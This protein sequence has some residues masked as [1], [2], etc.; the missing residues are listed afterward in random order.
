MSESNDKLR[1]IICKCCGGRCNTDQIWDC[2]KLE[3]TQEEILHIFISKSDVEKAI[4]EVRKDN[5]SD[6]IFAIRAL[7]QALE[8]GGEK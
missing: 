7:K 2:C 3:R 4:D 1:E 5:Y 6:M 8:L